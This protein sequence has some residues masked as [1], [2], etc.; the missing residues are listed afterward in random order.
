MAIRIKA[1]GGESA[2]QMMRRFKKMCEK[3]GLTKDIK[4]RAYFEKPS[5]RRRRAQ[6]KSV[7]RLTMGQ[8]MVRFTR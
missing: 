7:K 6:R 4:R 5:E 2:E 1:R 8:E 3:E